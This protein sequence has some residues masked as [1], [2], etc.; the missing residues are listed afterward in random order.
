MSKPFKFIG[1]NYTSTVMREIDEAQK[2]RCTLNPFRV[3]SIVYEI[4]KNHLIIN[5]P[6]DLGYPIEE[7]FDPDDKK[8]KIFLD[9]SNN[10]KSSSPALR[11][12]VFVYRGE[13]A[14]DSGHKTIG[15]NV[16][17]INVAESEKTIISKVSMPIIINCIYGPVGAAE[18][19]ADYIKHPFLYFFNQIEEEYCFQRF[20]LVKISEPELFTV[21]AKDN[22]SVKLFIETE[23]NETWTVKGDHLKL[24]T[25]NFSVYDSPSEK[26]LE[27]Q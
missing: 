22:F 16:V 7:V 14:Y 25:V 26:P 18:I 20:K 12:A 21:D 8:T 13:A 5:K 2:K 11:P 23:F 10:W 4:L 27:N 3:Q 17:G 24:K 9:M 1:S 6:K 15:G 19:F